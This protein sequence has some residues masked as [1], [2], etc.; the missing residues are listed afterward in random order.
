[1]TDDYYVA[2][3]KAELERRR[4]AKTYS[5]QNTL[6]RERERRLNIERKRRMQPDTPEA[7][8]FNERSVRREHV[9]S[10]QDWQR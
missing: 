3:W 5:Y 8:W 2:A 4:T 9:D 10:E 6:R 1:M 7:F